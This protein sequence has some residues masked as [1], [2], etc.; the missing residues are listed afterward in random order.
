MSD[1]GDLDAEELG[2][3]RSRPSAPAALMVCAR[4][5]AE[6]DRAHDAADAVRRPH[7]EGVVPLHALLELDGEVADG[8]GE[9]CR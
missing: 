4:E 6:Q 2:V 9:Q 5:D 7:V 1:G 8:A 3:A